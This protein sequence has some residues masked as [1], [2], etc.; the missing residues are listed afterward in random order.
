MKYLLAL[1]LLFSSVVRAEI[2]D[3]VL[4][5]SLTYHIFDPGG[6]S[7]KFSN[8]VDST[9][10]LISN[11]LAGYRQIHTDGNDYFS[12]MVFAGE[13]SIAEPILGAV[14]SFGLTSGGFRIGPI[15]GF[16]FQDNKKMLDKG[17]LPITLI[18]YAGWSPAPVIGLELVKTY[19][20]NKKCYFL[21]NGL[22]TPILL[23]ASIGVGWRI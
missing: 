10:M 6:I 18:P 7:K 3:E 14:W 13:N 19:D 1:L 4:V 21:L 15:V 9:G 22:I 16:Y 17:I 23:N 2:A 5:G 8:K 20:L 11:P 12:E